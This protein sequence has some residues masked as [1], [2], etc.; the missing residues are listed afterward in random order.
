MNINDLKFAALRAQGHTGAMPDM[1]LQWLQAA[2]ATA[3]SIPDSWNQVLTSRGYDNQYNTGL[4]TLLGDLG[5]DGSLP[6]RLYSFWKDGG[7][8]PPVP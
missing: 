3:S 5:Y 4:H 8:L 7:I 2:G 1:T 6:D